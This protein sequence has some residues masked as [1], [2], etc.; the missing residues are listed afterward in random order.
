L[1]DYIAQIEIARN[2]MLN[3]Y[4]YAL[5][6]RDFW[7]R[8]A[9]TLTTDGT[10][11]IH[12]HLQEEGMFEKLPSTLKNIEL[13]YEFDSVSSYIDMGYYH[14]TSNSCEDINETTSG[15]VMFIE[16]LYNAKCYTDIRRAQGNVSLSQRKESLSL[17]LPK[18]F[19]QDPSQ[20]KHIWGFVLMVKDAL[21]SSHGAMTSRDTTIYSYKC[22]DYDYSSIPLD[23]TFRTQIHNEVFVI[24]GHWGVG[25]YHSLIEDLPRLAPYIIFL[26]QN[27]QIKIHAGNMKHIG[28]MLSLIGISKGRIVLGNVTAKIAYFPSAYSCGSSGILNFKLLTD[29]LQP[30]ESI[31]FKSPRTILLIQ[32]TTPHRLFLHHQ[33]I[34]AMLQ[35]EASSKG[36]LVVTFADDPA[37]SMA[38]TRFMFNQAVMV[39]APHG[40]GLSNIIFCKP[41]TVIIEG[42]HHRDHTKAANTCFLTLALAL[43]HRYHGVYFKDRDV[44]DHRPEDYKDAV[45]FYL[46]HLSL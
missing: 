37:P 38:K 31:L 41:G 21:I 27:L 12:L 2:V 3:K 8:I 34:L 1:S 46:N 35:K 43:G 7:S 30:P 9:L 13:V 42:L 25:Y 14:Y 6:S 18:N 22:H 44:L 26:K 39:V 45:R 16:K 24:T 17:G 40:A 4:D 33:D 29:S 15:P 5:P 20:E 11:R 19:Q 28:D 36:L 10:K 32:R 23:S